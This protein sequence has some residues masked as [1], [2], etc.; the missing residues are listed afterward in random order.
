L[1]N[2]I[3]QHC[4]NTFRTSLKTIYQPA[5][6]HNGHKMKNKSSK[7]PTPIVMGGGKLLQK[8]Y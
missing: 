2:I 1:E 4:K 6:S 5:V 7:E 8:K 3:S